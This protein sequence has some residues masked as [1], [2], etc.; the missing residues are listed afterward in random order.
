MFV[1]RFTVID[2][3]ATASFVAP[4]SALKALV[5]AC[6]LA[7]ANVEELLSATEPYDSD[8]KEYVMNGLAVFDEHNT[9][10][11]HDQIH[12]AI[13]YADEQ[14]S[15]HQIPAF[16]VVD[17][18]TREASLQPVMAGLVLFN[19]KERR[20]IQVQN[21]YAEVRRED[22]GRIH[23]DGEPTKKLYKYRLPM[24]WQILP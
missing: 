10:G 17:P 15:H 4:C 3:Q 20:I 19:L 21:T 6:A 5:A 12:S 8:L 11:S 18:V 7:P 24:E 14:R 2:P 23:K 13:S 1:M 22:R 16:R 9:N